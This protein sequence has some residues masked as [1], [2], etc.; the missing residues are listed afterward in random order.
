[1]TGNT[2]ISDGI[3]IHMN[4]YFVERLVCIFEP[5]SGSNSVRDLHHLS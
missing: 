5:V 4:E 2:N 1:M 3:L